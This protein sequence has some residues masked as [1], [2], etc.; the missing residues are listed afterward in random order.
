MRAHDEQPVAKLI[1]HSYLD[2]EIV[3]LIYLC[4]QHSES[5]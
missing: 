3:Y 1:Q 4:E 5:R 2:L